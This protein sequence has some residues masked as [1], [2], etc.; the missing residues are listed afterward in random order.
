MQVDLIDSSGAIVS[1]FSVHGLSDVLST[2]D[3]YVVGSKRYVVR[4]RQVEV[5]LAE[6]PSD[7]F[8]VSVLVEEHRDLLHG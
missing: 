3:I 2:G 4:G 7:S 8:K 6:G 1:S 5:S